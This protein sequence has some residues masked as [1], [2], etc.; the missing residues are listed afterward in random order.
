VSDLAKESN[1]PH[2]LRAL[3]TH[4]WVPF[5]GY[6]RAQATE[7]EHGEG[8]EGLGGVEAERHPMQEPHAGV[9]RLGAPGA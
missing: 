8:D 2:H 9:G 1:A 3:L 4:A 5:P 7:L 6:G